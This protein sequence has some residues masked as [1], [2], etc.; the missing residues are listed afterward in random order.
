MRKSRSKYFDIE[1]CV[2]ATMVASGVGR[3]LGGG[4]DCEGRY[5]GKACASKLV[6]GFNLSTTAYLGDKEWTVG[7]QEDAWT[8]PGSCGN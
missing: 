7:F 6:I 2:D 8:W 4:I 3:F 5:S 1:T